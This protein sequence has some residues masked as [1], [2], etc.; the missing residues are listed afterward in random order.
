MLK[1]PKKVQATRHEW[2]KSRYKYIFLLVS[3]SPP[4]D[5]E[6]KC[7]QMLVAHLDKEQKHE[8]NWIN[9]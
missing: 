3:M 9:K 5:P 4:D 7:S 1:R 6:M 8:Q 2:P